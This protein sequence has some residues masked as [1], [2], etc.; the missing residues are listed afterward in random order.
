MDFI[1]WFEP[2]C[3]ITTF[4]F[5]KNNIVRLNQWA[6]VENFT[7]AEEPIAPQIQEINRWELV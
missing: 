5:M 6:I 3:P 2:F 1:S 4:M 7:E